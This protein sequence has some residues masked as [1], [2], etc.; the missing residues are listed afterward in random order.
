MS[1][2]ER[3]GAVPHHEMGLRPTL[4]P[5]TVFRVMVFGLK[6]STAPVPGGTIGGE[7]RRVY[8]ERPARVNR[9]PRPDPTRSA[10]GTRSINRSAPTPQGR[11]FAFVAA[12]PAR[13][14]GDDRHRVGPSGGYADHAGTLDAIA[15]VAPGDSRA[16]SLVVY[17]VTWMAARR[18]AGVAGPSRRARGAR[19]AVGERPRRPER[20]PGHPRRGGRRQDGPPAPLR[21]AGVRLPRRAGSPASSPRWSCRSRDCIS[22]ARRCSA[23][24]TRFPSRSRPPWASRSGL[25]SGAAPDR[26]LVALAALSLLAEVAAERPLLC[27]V[28]DAQWLD[29][30]SAQVLGFVARRLLA[31]SVAIVFAVRD[32][33][34]ER[35][36]VGLPE[37][38]LARAPRGGRARP[39]RD[40][41][42]GPARRARPRPARRGDARQPAGDPGAAA[43]VGRDAAAGRVRAPRAQRAAR[44]DRG[45]L[46]AAAR[47][48]PR[49]TRACCCWW[50]RR[51][52]SDDPL[53]LLARGRATRDRPAMPP[54]RQRTG[55][56]RSASA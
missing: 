51:S 6:T 16:A 29:A 9:R 35:E 32:P 7:T 34:D 41:H 8:I 5:R 2:A 37:L 4:R 31:E 12:G 50:R 14:A 27:L 53:L 55:C 39:A 13:A 26:F 28:D 21:S 52:P 49:R 54:T 36:L 40:G 20:G 18:P 17:A 46:P 43:G 48:A 1:S 42:P 38:T 15:G 33:T 24:S 23:G 10:S 56:W 47:V 22:S 30:A 3:H 25:S 45:E 11:R 44:A 19:P